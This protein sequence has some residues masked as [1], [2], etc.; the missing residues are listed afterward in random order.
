LGGVARELVLLIALA[1]LAGGIALM[2]SGWGIH[3]HGRNWPATQ[4]VVTQSG[5]YNS[6]RTKLWR[7]RI[8]CRYVVAGRGLECEPVSRV[9]AWEYAKA[10]NPL[11]TAARFKI[12]ASVTLRY[13]PRDPE[14]AVL[15]PSV[16]RDVLP[17]CLLGGLFVSGSLFLL[18][19]AYA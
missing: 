16:I 1:L 4:A 3:R 8:R 18:W 17:F 13:D 2:R 19:H 10:G 5:A 6:Y 12:G 14:H 7:A 9:L 15:Q 11:A